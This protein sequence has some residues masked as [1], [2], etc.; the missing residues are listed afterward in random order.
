MKFKEI[1]NRI[2]GISC[3]IFGLEW[4]PSVLESEVARKVIVYLEDRR[5]LYNPYEM[6][7]PNNCMDSIVQIRQFLTIK[8]SEL[9]ATSKLGEILRGMRGSC[10][11]FLDDTQKGWYFN[12]K[13]GKIDN[14]RNGGEIKFYSDMG[15][16]RGEMGIFIVQILIMYGVDCESELLEIVPLTLPDD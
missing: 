7:L 5:V 6:E 15:I 13:V 10:R 3:P 4:N 1:A 2:T 9:N 8:I 12:K 16:F 11:R 14:L